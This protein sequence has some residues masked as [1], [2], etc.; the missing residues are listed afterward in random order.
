ML[1]NWA[2][3][4]SLVKL[5]ISFVCFL[6]RDGVDKSKSV[7]LLVRPSQLK[8]PLSNVIVTSRLTF[9]I[10]RKTPLSDSSINSWPETVFEMKLVL[11]SSE[12]KFVKIVVHTINVCDAAASPPFMHLS[13]SCP[14]TPSRDRWGIWQPPYQMASY[15]ARFLGQIPL[16]GT[17]PAPYR[18]TLVFA[19]I[20]KHP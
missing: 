5:I 10:Q 15:R 13:M 1:T 12:V 4:I 18:R 20:L 3:Y 9:R 17:D 2:A 6:P 14:A 19:E 11:L 8:V 7:E 16:L